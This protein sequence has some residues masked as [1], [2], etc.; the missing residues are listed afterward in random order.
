MAQNTDP[1]E[2]LNAAITALNRPI[3]SDPDTEMLSLARGPVPPIGLGDPWQLET[4]VDDGSLYLIPALSLD[5][6]FSNIQRV[7]QFLEEES[8]KYYDY[9]RQCALEGL[10]SFFT[11]LDGCEKAVLE[12]PYEI[13]VSASR[14]CGPY[15]QLIIGEM[16]AREKIVEQCA[17]KVFGREVHSSEI[18]SVRATFEKG[19]MNRHFFRIDALIDDKILRFGVKIPLTANTLLES[20]MIFSRISNVI[21][22]R[23]SFLFGKTLDGRVVYGGEYHEGDN[24]AEIIRDGRIN[25][26]FVEDV[27]CG[28]VVTS[29]STWRGLGERFIRDPHP[30]QFKV[31]S[32]KG[33]LVPEV[34]LVDK[35]NFEGDASQ[36][37]IAPSESG[38]GLKLCLNDGQTLIDDGAG[39]V[40]RGEVEGWFFE[41]VPT[42]SPKEF[43][44]LLFDQLS[45]RVMDHIPP[46]LQTGGILSPEIFCRGVLEAL[47]EDDSKKFF[48]RYLNERAPSDCKGRE[49]FIYILDYLAADISTGR[50]KFDI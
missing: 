20:E 39:V 14:H 46:R 29:V 48:I 10:N 30:G 2:G 37:L 25:Y 27:L 18:S 5:F 13:I 15:N 6:Q 4:K 9:D 23:N 31:D 38:R 34:T 24:V 19:G 49:D 16:I 8:K 21:L 44:F 47:G 35:G 43:A 41:T 45:T 33:D 17:S 11:I 12:A 42:M 36:I 50:Y 22:G 7:F 28:I 26:N 1:T 32:S 40:F 3:S